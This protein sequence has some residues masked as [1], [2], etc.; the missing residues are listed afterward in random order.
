MVGNS[1][2]FGLCPAWSNSMVNTAQ[3]KKS[4]VLRRAVVGIVVGLVLY[5][6]VCVYAVIA[7]IRNM[8][9]LD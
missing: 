2:S 3:P 4:R 7:A 6:A 5:A 8:D 1:S 9:G